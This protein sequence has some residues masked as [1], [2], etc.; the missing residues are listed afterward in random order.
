MKLSI[1]V[2]PSSSKNCL[3]GWLEKTLKIKVM[4]APEK[5]KANKAV[6]QFLEEKLGLSKGSI[7]IQS[8]HKTPKKILEISPILACYFRQVKIIYLDY[9]Y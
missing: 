5:G 1:K 4:A 6:I 7:I 8:G 3:A 2:I 9:F